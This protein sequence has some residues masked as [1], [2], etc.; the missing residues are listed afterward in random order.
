M[1]GGTYACWSHLQVFLAGATGRLGARIL[2]ALLEADPAVKVRA[3]ARNTA[4]GQAFLDTAV[5]IGALPADAAGRVSV[6]EVDL[7]NGEDIRAAIG[8]ASKV[9]SARRLLAMTRGQLFHMSS[10]A[11]QV[12]QAIGAP[13]SEPFNFQLPKQI[14]EPAETGLRF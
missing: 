8:G 10:G 2:R 3:A 6:V 14:G 1:Y 5:G 12:V 4:R 9:G 7:T 11:A 13:E